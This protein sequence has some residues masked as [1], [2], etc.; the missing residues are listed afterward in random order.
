L[1]VSPIGYGAS[2]Y[3]RGQVVSLFAGTEM[4]EPLVSK[5][6][7]PSKGNLASDTWRDRSA[8]KR[9]RKRP[10]LVEWRYSGNSGWLRRKYHKWR[11]WSAYET[12]KQR[13]HALEQKQKSE[14]YHFEYRA[15]DL[16]E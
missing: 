8:T 12:R 11:K 9:G 10:F 13:D 6:S 3:R 1:I 15:I 16:S 5:Q 2:R 4:E 7:D 14:R